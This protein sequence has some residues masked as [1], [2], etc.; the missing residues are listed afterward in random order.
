MFFM[1]TKKDRLVAFRIPSEFYE[2]LK[3]QALKDNRKV[4]NL[5]ETVLIDYLKK[6]S[7]HP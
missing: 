3:E 1:K 7:K 5:I 4:A 2:R 6:Q